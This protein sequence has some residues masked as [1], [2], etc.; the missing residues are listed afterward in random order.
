MILQPMPAEFS[1]G[2]HYHEFADEFFF[3]VSGS[4]VATISG[5]DQAVGPGDAIFVPAGADHKIATR[6][7]PMELL[8]FLDRPGLDDEFRAEIEEPVTLEK[9]NEVANRY[10][11][12]YRTL[13]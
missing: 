9:L 6:A 13:E 11:T 2:I 4:G 5:E 7:G 8:E 12:V 3:V 10:G 1:T